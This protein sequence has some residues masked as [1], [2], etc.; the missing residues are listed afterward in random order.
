MISAQPDVAHR[1][2]K[3]QFGKSAI[4]TLT[5][6]ADRS[7]GEIKP[8][9]FNPL[10]DTDG[11]KPSH[12]QQ[13]PP[14]VDTIFDYF[15]S[16]GSGSDIQKAIGVTGLPYDKTMFFGLQYMVKQYLT[17]PITPAMVEEADEFYSKYFGR[18]DI[19]NKEGWMKIATELGGRLPLEIRA[20]KE[21]EAVDKS[22]VLLTV[23]NTKP[24]YHWL[25]G[26]FET[27]LMR[28]WYPISVAT[29]S[30]NAKMVLMKALQETSDN[31]EAVIPYM[32]HDFGARGVTTREAAAV[33]GMAHL[34]NFVG[35]DT[36][37]GVRHAN[38]YYHNDMSGLS[39]PAAEH[40]TITSWGRD[41]EVDAFRNMVKQ[42]A[43]PG[44]VFAVV[45][46]SYD[47][48]QAL[49]VWGQLKDEIVSKGATVVVR[50]DSGDTVKIICDSLQS[51]EQSY[52]YTVNN[53]G[54]KVLK[55]ARVIQ[56]DGIDVSDMA[57]ILDAAK[58]LGYSADNL[59]FGMGGGLLQKVNRDSHKFAIKACAAKRDGRWVEV[60]KDPATDPGK[61]SKRGLFDLIKDAQ[62]NFKSVK[63]DPEVGM[64]NHSELVT[65]FKD[66]FGFND[67]TFAEVR[68]RSNESLKKDMAR[69]FKTQQGA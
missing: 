2:P 22:N 62:G 58:K 60:Y 42:Y 51:L 47:Y 3:T 48:Y 39:I 52:G 13:Y 69:I 63:V 7:Y 41:G 16:R 8:L 54:Y 57:L 30:Y 38:Y 18:K 33:G 21:G 24:G 56:G 32:L 12:W 27:M 6:N 37:E 23:K 68:A 49:G 4:P 64:S 59:V 45:S 25:V 9:E 31:P 61:V 11:Y 44:A 1:L 28:A 15:E 50:P 35:S 26:W 29:T 19:F 34:V 36:I 55:N 40:S 20:V 17:K 5:L 67:Q 14:G 46:D 66:G 43:K 10:L 65:Y 53:K